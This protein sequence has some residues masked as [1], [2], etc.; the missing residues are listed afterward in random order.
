LPADAFGGFWGIV[1]V[2]GA[3]AAIMLAYFW[4]KGWFN[5]PRP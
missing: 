3:F 1:C 2:M 5:P 4:R